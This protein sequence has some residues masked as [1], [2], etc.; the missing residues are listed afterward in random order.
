MLGGLC[1]GRV[2]ATKRR[3]K[4]LMGR[5]SFLVGLRPSSKSL[6]L[7]RLTWAME[8]FM[9]VTVGDEF[10]VIGIEEAICR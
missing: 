8:N 4:L 1:D 10:D 2:K 7:L 9:A 6:E 3:G 5:R